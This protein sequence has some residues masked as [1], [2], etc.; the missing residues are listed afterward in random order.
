MA[1]YSHLL[2][3]LDLSPESQQVV[4]RVKQLFADRDVK[5]SICHILEPLAFT[6]GGDIP[7]DLSDVQV[8]LEDQARTRLAALAE[9]LAIPEEDQHIVLGQ[10]A[11][12]MRRMAKEED[13]DL[14]IVGSHGRHGLALIFGSTSNSVLHGAPCDV[15]A[16]RIAEDD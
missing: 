5:I 6:Y 2:I 10:P 12:E 15:L 7:V 9:Q 3:G 1:T 13:V 16:V 14:I 11:N 8:Q 4:D